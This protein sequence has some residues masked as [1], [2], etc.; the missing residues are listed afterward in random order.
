MISM[1]DKALTF[2]LSCMLERNLVAFLEYVPDIF[3]VQRRLYTQISSPTVVSKCSSRR[4]HGRN[5]SERFRQL[6]K[7]VLAKH[8][9]NQT[10]PRDSQQPTSTHPTTLRQPP[11]PKTFRGLVI[12]DVPKAPE[13]DGGCAHL[14]LLPRS[15]IFTECCM[16]GCAVCVYDLYQESV[17]AYK[18]AVASVRASLSS[19]GVPIEQWPDNIRPGSERKLPPPISLS[20]FE[21]LER[22]LDA[23]RKA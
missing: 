4:A 22:E 14:L 8:N 6:E 21:E 13:S 19:M 15:Y 10:V 17:D 23:R 9:L 11:T 12:P 2:L 7:T 18:F 5:L 3:N 20:A 16:S 1:D